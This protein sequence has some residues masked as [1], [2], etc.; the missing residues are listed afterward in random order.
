MENNKNIAGTLAG[1][2]LATLG[3]VGMVIWGVKS[4]AILAVVVG[5]LGAFGAAWPLVFPDASRKRAEETKVKQLM[6]RQ[7]G[8]AAR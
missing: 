1:L 6:A 4:P 5:V 7:P 2:A 8:P 3:V